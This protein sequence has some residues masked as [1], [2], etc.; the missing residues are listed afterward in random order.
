MAASTNIYSAKDYRVAIAEE[1]AMGT[2]ITSQGSFKELQITEAPQLDWGGVIRESVKRSN[3]KRV[4]D[5]RDVYVATAGGSYTVTVT[6]VLTDLTVDLLTYGVMQDL[7]SEAGSGTY[8][9]IF[10]WDSSTTQP[11]FGGNAGKY[12]TLLLARPAAAES[13]ALT[14]CVIQ[15]LTITGDPGANG[16]RLGFS[17]TFYTGYAPTY[18]STATTSSWVSSGTDYYV[19]QS[20]SAKT[21]NSNDVV[22]G[23][24][25][26]NWE[27]GVARVGYDS[28][29]NP[30]TYAMGLGDGYSF[31]GEVSA[32]YDA[33]TKDLVD[34]WLT[35]PTAGS[36][37]HNVTLAWGSS[38]SDGY[39]KFDCNAIYAGNTL[40]FG[41]EAGVFVS[42]PFE[43]VDDGSNE[44]IEV[45]IEN[46]TDRSW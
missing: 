18:S 37:E 32:K 3:G 14:S 19:F 8:A 21:I 23:S 15:S 10:E 43:G 20:A 29:G 39:L 28:S 46:S 34:T 9:K 27:N 40:D 24:F 22:V 6:G 38:G 7:V 1:S 41:N 17:A 11:D 45:T 31:T 12:Y 2:A 26:L 13:I 42:L 30:E 16:G 5:Y 35:N 25:S 33:N 36:A 4:K 44:A